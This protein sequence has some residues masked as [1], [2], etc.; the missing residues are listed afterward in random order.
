MGGVD[1]C[2]F[3]KIFVKNFKIFPFKQLQIFEQFDIIQTHAFKFCLQ[4]GFEY[5]KNQSDYDRLVEYCQEFETLA[6]G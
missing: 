5:G 4:G 2:Y 3:M 6:A 1:L